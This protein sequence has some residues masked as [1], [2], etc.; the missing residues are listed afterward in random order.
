MGET[1]P[2]QVILEVVEG[3]QAGQQFAFDRHEAFVVGRKENERVQFKIPQDPYLSRY[4]F[5]IDVCPP[6]CRIRDLGSRNGTRVNKHKVREARLKD[7][8]VIRAGKT[9]M[10]VK[11]KQ[12]DPAE[13]AT[14]DSREPD[15]M[16]TR[17]FGTGPASTGSSP[18]RCM[19]CNCEPDK[20]ALLGSLTDTSMVT[21]T[22][23]ECRKKARGSGQIIPNYQKLAELGSGA[24]GTVYKAR[25]VDSGRLTALKMISPE[26]AANPEA[27]ELFFREMRV[28]MMLKH[29]RIVEVVEMGQT[30]NDLWIASE[31]VDGPDAMQLAGQKGGTLPLAD[32]VAIVCQVLEGLQYAH[33]KNLVHRDVKPPNILVSGRPGAYQAWLA[34]FGLMK[35][36]DEA[37]M[38]EYTRPGE[39]RGTLPFMPPEQVSDC[40]FVKPEGDVYAAGATLYWLLTGKFVYDFE[41][42]DKN[43]KPKDPYLIIL[44]EKQ[45]PEPI[46]KP[47]ESIPKPVAKVVARSL[48]HEPEDRFETAAEMAHALERAVG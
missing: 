15:M 21:Y 1:K 44:D 23:G 28:T 48:A 27:A 12:G 22:C 11:I 29:P 36:I 7:G 30:G 41:A 19:V 47:D 35:N 13:Q 20:D 45:D 5:L 18:L 25:Q 2:M 43:G 6:N 39:V 24:L 9:K 10:R 8:D 16:T 32:A 46:K 42:P 37:G 40:R 3:P 31:L 17:V 38:S 34:D 14:P 26:M 4:H 33:R